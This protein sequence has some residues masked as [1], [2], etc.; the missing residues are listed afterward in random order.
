M[1]DARAM[2]RILLLALAALCSFAAEDGFKPMFNG[3]DLSG[4]VNVNGAPETWSISNGVV[5][6][7]GF[8]TG[9]MRTDRQYENF[10]LELEWRHLSSGGNSGVFLWGS[11]IGAPGVPFLRG[12]EV[13]V[14]D[15]G[16]N[17]NGKNQ[18]YT[19]HGD[20]FP[21]HG[22]TMKPFGRHNGMRSFPSEERSKPSPD[23]NHYRITATNG[24]VRLEVNGKEVSGG[25]DCNYRKG[26]LALESEGAPIEFRNVR[27]KE[28]PSGN[29]PADQTAPLDD[30]FRTIF[31]GLD[32]RGFEKAD[33]WT[34]SGERLRSNGTNALATTKNFSKP[35]LIL[36]VK[37]PADA[38]LIIC[39]KPQKLE[40]KDGYQ[41]LHIKD[42]P[43]GAI[44]ISGK[45]EFMNLYVKDGAAADVKEGAK[46]LSPHELGVGRLVS[47]L[48]LR[49]A[50]TTVIAFTSVTCP[51][52]QRYAPTLASIGKEFS[53]RGVDFLFVN[54]ISAESMS[55]FKSFAKKH[56]LK[57]DLIRD[58][59]ERFIKALGASSTTEVF[60]LD[61][62]RTLVYRGAVDDQ[63]GLGFSL[64]HP[65]HNYLRDAIQASLKRERPAIAATTA[66][67]CALESAGPIAASTKDLTYH[68][69]IS[70]IVE[71]HCAECH[72]VGG[73]APFALR[74][75]ED[76][77]SRAAMVAKQV[78]KGIM[79]PWFATPGQHWT[80]DRSLPEADKNDLLEWLRG[81]RKLGNPGDAP[82]PRTFPRDWALGAPDLVLRIPEPIAVNATGTMPYQNV[83]I[84]PGFTEDQWI[85]AVEVRPTARQVVHHVLV[86]VIPPGQTEQKARADREGGNFLAV[87]VPG[88]NLLRYPAD[89]GKVI[90]AGS[91]LHFQIH[92][93]P[94]GTPTSDQTEVA[95]IF[96]KETPRYE[97]RVA[98]ISAKL[99]IPPGEANYETR[100]RVPVMFD[101]KLLSFMPHM[102]VRGKSYR[103]ELELPSGERQLL[104]DVP[105]YD[106]NWQI[107]YRA[108]SPIEAPAGSVLIG[109]AQYDN[110]TNNP[111]NPDATQRVRWGEQ[112]YEEMMLGYFEFYVPAQEAG[113]RVNLAELAT[114]DGGGVFVS[115]DKNRDGKLTANESPSAR[116]FERADTDNDGIVTREEFTV[117]WRN[118]RR[119]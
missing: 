90:P 93:T 16:F 107:Q 106:F 12:I 5:R 117:F 82:L 69:R 13:Q 89:F 55:D 28:L 17:I 21:I 27:I 43:A 70:R 95:M 54:P 77:V 92:Y 58:Q 11:P 26:Y 20:V 23:W 103:Y 59:N 52:S 65:R 81:P 19:T 56:G 38:E 73:V 75:F 80:N 110:S 116:Q 42:L 15:H 3:R 88:N 7:T 40:K 63:Y 51:V 44:T 87:Y 8:P 76:L 47:G 86:H 22:A 98:A 115:L 114:R 39:G 71:E 32:L 97:V 68:G 30:G 109:T 10:I 50:K 111:A 118:Q 25:S 9:A 29:P 35:E 2:L 64:E 36:D 119:R 105:R 78:D 108:A 72:R 91:K 84:D 66:P 6:C 79:P 18:W 104:L 37:A 53:K 85:S 33:G 34:V 24:V 57:G 74:S 14:L 62:A 60:V 61:A 67:G 96:A 101:A 49:K 41:R 112:T 102:H 4:W 100:G 46:V 113:K 83:Y 1:G 99:D 48:P 31:N 94:N 45:G